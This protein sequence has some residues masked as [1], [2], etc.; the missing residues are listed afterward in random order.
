MLTITMQRTHGSSHMY[1]YLQSHSALRVWESAFLNISVKH[2]VH[3]LLVLLE[4]KDARL[5][6]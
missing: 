3:L 5:D 6:H 1:I 2:P 4:T